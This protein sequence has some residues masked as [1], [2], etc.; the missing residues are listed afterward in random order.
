MVE[1]LKDK[2]VFGRTENHLALVRCKS[3]EHAQR[4]ADKL[5]ESKIIVNVNGMFDGTWGIRIGA[6]Y[7]TLALNEKLEWE[8]IGAYINYVI[9]NLE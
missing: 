3:K 1:P 8:K 6:T 9:D 2:L 5:E 7:E 4:V